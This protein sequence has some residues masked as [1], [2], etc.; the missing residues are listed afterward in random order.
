M[1]T[2][3]DI[4]AVLNNAQ[5][6]VDSLA[7]GVD[8]LARPSPTARLSLR[9]EPMPPFSPAAVQPTPQPIT[10]AQVPSEKARVERIRRLRVPVVVRLA[11]RR[12][13]LSEVMKIVPG[14]I[15]EFDRTVDHELD[16]LVNNHQVGAGVAVKVDEHFGLRVTYVGNLK[17]RI[18][19]LSA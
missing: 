16:L 2:Q 1:F 3:E 9:P 11:Q 8:D 14:T 18:Q 5:A 10:F 4:D 7:A 15:L 12:M 19:S 13:P 17:Q 6:A